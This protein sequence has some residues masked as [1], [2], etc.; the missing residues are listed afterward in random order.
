MTK[1]PGA[2]PRRKL[3]ALV[4]VDVLMKPQPRRRSRLALEVGVVLVAKVVALALIWYVW[5][6]DPVARHLEPERIG[7]VVYSSASAPAP[8]GSEHARP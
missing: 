4:L 6:A 8:T 5:F 3:A 1:L 7:A 2:R